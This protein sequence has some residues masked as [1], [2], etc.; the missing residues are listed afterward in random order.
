MTWHFKKTFHH[1]L[2]NLQL[3]TMTTLQNIS[4]HRENNWKLS[5]LAWYATLPTQINFRPCFYKNKQ[6]SPSGNYAVSASINAILVWMQTNVTHFDVSKLTSWLLLP[7]QN[8]DKRRFSSV[9][10]KK[11]R[12]KRL[13]SK[14]ILVKL[15]KWT[16]PPPRSSRKLTLPSKRKFVY[17]RLMNFF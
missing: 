8:N 7:H 2:P 15:K 17:C 9:K 3:Y 11:T 14:N 4:F 16:P 13:Y 1:P 6:L 5:Q 10:T 12:K